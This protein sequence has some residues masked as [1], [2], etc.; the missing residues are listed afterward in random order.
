M[1]G[2]ILATA[3]VMTLCFGVYE[4]HA[5]KKGCPSVADLGV[6]EKNVLDAATGSPLV[7]DRLV[8]AVQQARLLLKQALEC[9]SKTDHREITSVPRSPSRED[10][11]VR[12][13]PEEMT[14]RLGRTHLQPSVR[15]GSTE[16]ARLAN[17]LTDLESAL[18][19]DNL[20]PEVVA[21]AIRRF[22][23]PP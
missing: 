10:V 21:Q 15:S 23:R 12:P 6:V 19:A 16:T 18:A 7:A 3:S 5:S 4:M 2:K 11:P 1:L 17:L 13:T 14:K 9:Q 8:Q 22:Q 20:D